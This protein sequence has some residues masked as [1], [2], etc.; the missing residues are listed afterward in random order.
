ML[1]ILPTK[2]IFCYDLLKALYINIGSTTSIQ[3]QVSWKQYIYVT[4]HIALRIVLTIKYINAF[5][6]RQVLRK[7]IFQIYIA[8][9]QIKSLKDP[10][11]TPAWRKSYTKTQY[12][13][14]NLCEIGTF[15]HILQLD[16]MP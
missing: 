3:N 7:K 10:L 11:L 5:Y 1:K 15:E 2:Y 9:Q 13:P 6:R 4:L 8:S 12:I 14:L 16:P